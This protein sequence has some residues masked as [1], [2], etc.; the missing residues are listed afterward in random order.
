MG[1][2]SSPLLESDRVRA[3]AGSAAGSGPTHTHTHGDGDDSSDED[4][5]AAFEAELEAAMEH[6]PTYTAH[7]SW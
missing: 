1:D 4:R 2:S 3:G 7:R 6:R 5:T